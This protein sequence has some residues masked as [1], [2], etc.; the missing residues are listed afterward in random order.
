[1]GP[2]DALNNWVLVSG[3]GGIEIT[4]EKKVRRQFFK[5]NNTESTIYIMTFKTVAKL[6]RW[7]ELF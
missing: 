3:V 6:L 4:F 2:D 1:M 5:E 7:T